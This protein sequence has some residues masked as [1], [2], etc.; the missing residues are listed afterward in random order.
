MKEAVPLL[1]D[2]L[3][4]YRPRT[5]CF[6]GRGIWD[7]FRN[8]A[9]NLK[10][11]DRCAAPA[12]SPRKHANKDSK[13]S[14]MKIPLVP[15]KYFLNESYKNLPH[16]KLEDKREARTFS[17]GLQPFKL[18]YRQHGAYLSSIHICISRKLIFY[19]DQKPLIVSE[20]LIFVVPS[21][22]ARV[23]AYQVVSTLEN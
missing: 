15:S 6:L 3:V 21:P 16:N 13:L 22:S 4:K 23:V 8:Q 10:A 18:V 14:Q 1:M 17:W 2:K 20:T 7:I 11:M 5:L 12:C 9:F 19:S